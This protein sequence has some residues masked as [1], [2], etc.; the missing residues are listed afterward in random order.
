MQFANFDMKL[1]S[2]RQFDGK[3]IYYSRSTEFQYQKKSP[4]SSS[5]VQQ[6]DFQGSRIVFD[7]IQ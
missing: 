4:T 2:K 3:M 5:Y 6:I 7:K 1:K